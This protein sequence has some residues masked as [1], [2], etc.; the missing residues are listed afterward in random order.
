MIQGRRAFVATTEVPDR[1]RVVRIRRAGELIRPASA[2]PGRCGSRTITT[3]ARTSRPQRMFYR[4]DEQHRSGGRAAARHGHVTF[5]GGNAPAE[6]KNISAGSATC[7]ARTLRPEV[8]RMARNRGLELSRFR[9]ERCIQHAGR[10]LRRLRGGDRHSRD[11]GYR[12]GSLGGRSAQ[13]PR[14]RA[15]LS[16]RGNG[17]PAAL[18]ASSPESRVRSSRRGCGRSRGVSERRTGRSPGP[19]SVVGTRPK[20]S[21]C[22]SQHGR[23]RFLGASGCRAKACLRPI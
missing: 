6:L 7:T 19:P 21:I 15:S 16:V 3:W 12:G 2:R 4:F 11:A 22:L 23:P 1:R 18:V 17:V 10:R 20:I 13:I 8:A 9:L 5:A 14:G